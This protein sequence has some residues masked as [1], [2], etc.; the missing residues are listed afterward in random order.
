MRAPEPTSERDSRPGNQLSSSDY[1]ESASAS[2]TLLPSYNVS[3]HG[4]CPSLS[5]TILSLS[6]TLIPRDTLLYP[7]PRNP[8]SQL[9]FRL[10]RTL[11]TCCRKPGDHVHNPRVCTSHGTWTSELTCDHR[12]F[13]AGGIAACGA[14]TVTHGFETVKI[15]LQLQ[16]ELQARKDAPRMYRGVFH[17]V[18]VIL[19]NEGPRGLLRGL[20]CAVR[21]SRRHV[22]KNPGLIRHST[23]TK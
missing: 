19:K 7:R 6:H 20:G 14:V 8:L 18:G 9:L 15:R 16:G 22:I 23:S 10:I 2:P 4:V 21:N 13:I 5:F 11:N 17:G 12:S 3:D 1:S